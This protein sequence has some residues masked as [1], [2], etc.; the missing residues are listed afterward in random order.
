M[1]RADYLEREAEV[2]RYLDG[3]LPGQ[4]RIPRYYDDKA[5]FG[6]MDVL[7]A[8]RP[9]WDQVRAEI[10]ADLGITQ[11]KSVGHV[12]STVHRGLQTDFFA[13][14]ERYLDSM[15]DFMSFNDLGN[16][17]GRICRRFDLKH[18]ERGL[19][20]V[21]RRASGNYTRDLELTQDFA[22][23]CQF[24]GLDHAR[25]RTGFASL[26]AIFEWVIASPWFSVAPYLDE[27]S[28][29]IQRRVQL[30]PTVARFVEYL[31]E[32][33]IDKRVAYE[34]RQAYLPMVIAAFPDAD[35]AAQIERE[36]AAEARQGALSARFNGKLVMRLVP[37]V[38]GKAL[39]ELIVRF[40]ASF[41][42]FDAWVLATP[43][44]DIERAIVAFAAS[45]SG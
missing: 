16:L 45:P 10:V 32:R 17:V 31:R 44:E 24:L 37:G 7:V 29:P 36:R 42:D 2:R 34:D 3:K 41:E 40:K 5:D 1:P 4:Y 33:G 23:V 8:S 38:E 15:H 20:Y 14:P 30:R 43:Q 22:R 39:G 26:P 6:D 11:I 28:G 19:A 21:Y 9:D 18:G 13:V 25:W 12:Y 27:P 35:L